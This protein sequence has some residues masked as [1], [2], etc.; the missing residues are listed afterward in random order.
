MEN[1]NVMSKNGENIMN[2]DKKDLKE[3]LYIA[4]SVCLV[5]LI[6]SI[7]SNIIPWSWLRTFVRVGFGLS[8]VDAITN[9]WKYFKLKKDLSK[10]KTAEE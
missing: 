10:S 5:L 2:I 1:V 3:D 8:L 4:Y 6:A 7:F 9:Q